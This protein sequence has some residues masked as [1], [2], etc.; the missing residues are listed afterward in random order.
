[1]YWRAAAPVV[2][3]HFSCSIQRFASARH[4]LGSTVA[5]ILA[6]V[7]SVISQ[8]LQNVGAHAAMDAQVF[9][10]FNPKRYSLPRSHLRIPMLVPVS[11]PVAG[12]LLS[13]EHGPLEV[14]V[15][16]L[17]LVLHLALPCFSL[18]R[19]CPTV[20]S[21]CDVCVCAGH[22]VRVRVPSLLHRPDGRS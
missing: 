13:C 1:M 22:P 17:A 12:D 6:A 11:C 18:A 7:S 4:Q 9:F 21:M 8:S 10:A 3:R 2:D 19:T 16:L 14:H 15:S 5:I 20:H